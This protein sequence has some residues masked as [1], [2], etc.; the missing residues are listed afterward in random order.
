MPNNHTYEKIKFDDTLFP[1]KIIWNTVIS[2]ENSK[3]ALGLN[4]WHEQLEILYML[5]GTAIVHCGYN[6]YR[7]V[8]GDI[9]V[10]NPGDTHWVEY[11]GEKVTYHC[12]IIDPKMYSGE[13]TDICGL[14][15]TFK[16]N[17]RNLR[18]NNHIKNNNQFKTIMDNLVNECKNR[19]YAY[20]VAVKGHILCLLAELFRNEIN[21]LYRNE[22]ELSHTSGYTVIEPA[23]NYIST[24]F[25][26]KIT[27]EELANICC[28]TPSHL[29][30]LFK[31]ITGKTATDYINEF[32]IAKARAL[33]LTTD[34]CI[35]DISTEVGYTDCGYFSR[36]FKAIHGFP[37]G[38]LRE[39]GLNDLEE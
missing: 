39:I 16:F 29:C 5:E 20:E 27:L 12:F 18:F 3:D 8:G 38:K 22:A 35:N 36:R 6:S 2:A 4:H 7:C 15:Y 25:A 10:V 26:S 24:N 9:I 21:A 23:F 1:I 28:V 33:L 14:K 37:P 11:A 13:G 17:S 30:R 32:R 34:K 31:K 19:E